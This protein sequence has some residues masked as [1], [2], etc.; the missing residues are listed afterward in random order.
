MKRIS[1]LVFTLCACLVPVAWGQQP[2]DNTNFGPISVPGTSVIFDPDNVLSTTQLAQMG[3]TAAVQALTFIAA[4]N[5]TFTFSASGL[6][7]CCGYADIG[8]D[9]QRGNSNINSLQSISGFRAP[10]QLPLVGVF[11]NGNPQGTPPHHYNY[12]RGFRV[13]KFSPRLNQVFFIGDGLT[14]TGKGAIQTFNV[15]ATATELWLG[16]A[17]AADFGGPPGQYADNPGS[18][19]VTGTLTTPSE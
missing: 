10:G 6:V 2:A 16:F 8:P 12:K 14:R 3:G 17:D 5:Q 18:L 9:G 11:T 13:K 1:I 4:D 15:P 7:G 19:T